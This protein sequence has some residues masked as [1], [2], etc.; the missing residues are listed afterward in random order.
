MAFS[1]TEIANLSQAHLGCGKPI[2]S[3]TES[4]KEARALNQFWGI[5]RQRALK[6]F[7]WPFARKYKTLTLKAEDPNEDWSRSYVYPPEALY[8][9]KIL[10]GSRIDTALSAV[11][12]LIAHDDDAQVIFTDREDAIARITMDVED[13]ARW[14]PDFVLAHSYFLAHLSAPRI[15]GGDGGALGKRALELYLFEI[16][17]AEANAQNEQEEGP[18]ATPSYIAARDS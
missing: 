11:P 6:D 17:K 3:L 15:L 2:A 14:S 9:R 1:E 8:V 12:F 16:S 7:D 5:A 18:P 10:S 4:S 13:P